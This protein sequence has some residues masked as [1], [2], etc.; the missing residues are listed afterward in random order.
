MILSH[1]QCWGDGAAGEM[2]GVGTWLGN[3][4]GKFLQN[5]FNAEGHT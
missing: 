2:Q 5:G 1:G 4:M 3:M